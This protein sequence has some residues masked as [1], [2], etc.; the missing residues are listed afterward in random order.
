MGISRKRMISH[1][2]LNLS[3]RF[4][5]VKHLGRSTHMTKKHVCA[6]RCAQ[7]IS[8]LPS[9]VGTA[10]CTWGLPLVQRGLVPKVTLLQEVKLT[11]LRPASSHNPPLSRPCER[12]FDRGLAAC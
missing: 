4:T 1:F 9:L 10:F 11:S 6:H 8:K 3:N 7:Q 2:L 12:P 5:G